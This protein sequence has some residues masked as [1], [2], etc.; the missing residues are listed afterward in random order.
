MSDT[1]DVIILGL[2]GMGLAA[3]DQLALR[4]VNVLGLE[5]FHPGHEQGS[6][7]GLTRI[8]REAY[9]EHPAYVPLVRRAFHLW[10]AL[11][12]RTGNHVLNSAPCLTIGSPEGAMIRGIQTAAREHAIPIETLSA[13][14]ISS[15]FPAFRVPAEHVGVLERNAGYLFVDECQKAHRGS[16]LAADCSEIEEYA[17]VISWNATSNGVVVQTT[18]EKYRAKKLIITAGAWSKKV[19]Q[20]V[21]VPLTVMRQTMHWFHPDRIENFLRDRL[22]IF[23]METPEGDF[24]GIPAINPLGLKVAR[25]YGAPELDG[26]DQ[27]NWNM[28]PED[29]KPVR[30]FLEKHLPEAAG[31]SG[32]SRP[33][34]YTLTPDRHFIIDTHPEH[35]NVFFA[36]GFSGHGYKFAT[37]IGEILADLDTTGTTSH[38]ISLFRLN[39]FSC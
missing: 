37:V 8:I 25:H 34:M 1:F 23:L 16:A 12:E 5:Q 3:L 9:Y 36:C 30:A 24:Y 13:T 10:Y 2:G 4:D 18:R 11:E 32:Y 27:V 15:R 38:D 28:T 35:D 39:R 26:P 19:L 33:C 31:R 21:G 20:K 6:S 7:H 29:E 17:K 14:E 22:P